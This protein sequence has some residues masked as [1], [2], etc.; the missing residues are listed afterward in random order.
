MKSSGLD[1]KFRETCAV[2]HLAQ[3]WKSFASILLVGGEGYAIRLKLQVFDCDSI[4][5]KKLGS[6]HY[7][8]VYHFVNASKIGSVFC[9]V[10]GVNC[11]YDHFFYFCKFVAIVS[12]S[13]ISLNTH[14]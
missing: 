5:Q 13:H 9:H 10:C 14:S 4:E 12:K 11:R 6:S 8:L 2:F 1:G 7:Q 3:P